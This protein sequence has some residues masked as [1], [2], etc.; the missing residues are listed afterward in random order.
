MTKPIYSIIITTCPTKAAAK[1]IANKLVAAK[2]SACVQISSPI[3][4]FYYWDNQ[5]QNDQEYRLQIKTKTSLFEKVKD[6]IQSNHPYDIPQII[7][8]PILEG[9]KAYLDWVNSVVS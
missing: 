6:I 5:I 2:V 8:V 7:L 9:N 1:K 3:E 4:S